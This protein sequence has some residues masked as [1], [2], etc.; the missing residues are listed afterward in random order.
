MVNTINFEKYIDIFFTE[1][2][3]PQAI[4]DNTGNFIKVNESFSKLLG[5]TVLEFVRKNSRA[6][7]HPEDIDADLEM[8]KGCLSEEYDGYSMVKRY[9]TKTGYAVWVKIDVR[10][11]KTE[12]ESFFIIWISPL[13]NG[14]KFKVEA[15]NTDL[16]VKPVIKLK[17]IFKDNLKTI[18]T[19]G[20]ILL[21]SVG[22]AI[23]T[24]IKAATHLNEIFEKLNK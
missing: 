15:T 21:M 18:I 22:G 9:L 8:H 17:D 13:P 24:F 4:L 16:V 12:L 3:I 11:I 7:T 19:I 2:P 10:Y 20:S 14:G 1:S 23:V 6:I 5:Y